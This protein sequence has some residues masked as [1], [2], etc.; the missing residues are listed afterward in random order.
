MRLFDCHATGGKV[1]R[2]AVYI[3]RAAPGLERSPLANPY[4]AKSR[5]PQPCLHAVVVPDDAVLERFKRRI[6]LHIVQGFRELDALRQLR[7]TSTLACWC[8]DRDA[9]LVVRNGVDAES[10]CHGDVIFT[11]WLALERI[12]WRVEVVNFLVD[13]DRANA[14][15]RELYRRAFGEPMQWRGSREDDQ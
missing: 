10:P 13:A 3:G 6:T 2:G 15:W 12:G 4:I 14:A 7:R 11:V 1:P 9:G 5:A 8:A